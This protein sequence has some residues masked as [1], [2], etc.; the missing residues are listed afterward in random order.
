M[1]FSNGVFLLLK[2]NENSTICSV[3]DKF[4]VFVSGV[5][6]E[7]YCNSAPTISLSSFSLIVEGQ[8]TG[9]L[10][11]CISCKL[12]GVALRLCSLYRDKVV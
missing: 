1:V 11:C 4:S 12:D 6:L 9:G 3:K 7:V 2:Y 5:L 10:M 8:P